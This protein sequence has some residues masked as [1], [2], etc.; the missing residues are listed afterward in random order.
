MTYRG[1]WARLSGGL[2][3]PGYAIQ[4]L[5]PLVNHRERNIAPVRPSLR[6]QL[7]S[8][9]YV[10][11]YHHDTL[12]V[13]S[14]E[15]ASHTALRAKVCASQGGSP[16]PPAPQ[17]HRAPS[18]GRVPAPRSHLLR[19]FQKEKLAFLHFGSRKSTVVCGSPSVQ[20]NRTRLTK[21]WDD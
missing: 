1:T 3:I 10:R 8:L 20:K 18:S 17:P 9:S 19:A 6:A 21:L 2:N 13:C 15:P 16:A 4:K 11:Y 5:A 14:S 12:L 7:L